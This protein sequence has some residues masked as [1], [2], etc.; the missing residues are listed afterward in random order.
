V[1]VTIISNVDVTWADPLK[2]RVMRA[3]ANFLALASLAVVLAFPGLL[4]A[5]LAGILVLNA[6]A[7]SGT[8]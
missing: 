2:E 3:A 7:A 6:G 5:G 1:D 4:T 8:E